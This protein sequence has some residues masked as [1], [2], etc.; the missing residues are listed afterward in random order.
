MIHCCWGRSPYTPLIRGEGL[1]GVLIYEGIETGRVK[2]WDRVMLVGDAP[3][4]SRFGFS[5]LQGIEMPPPTNPDRVLG[6]E[7]APG[8]WDGVR[9]LVRR[10]S[11]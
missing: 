1:G 4:Y 10:W 3:Y 8:V 6:L 11:R 9:G 7:L 2:G 5:L